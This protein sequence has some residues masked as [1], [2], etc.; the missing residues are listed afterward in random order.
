MR[1]FGRLM[2]ASTAV[3]LLLAGCGQ[4]AGSGAAANSS[5]PVGS[6]TSSAADS[7]RC[8][9]VTEDLVG[10][11]FG[12]PTVQADDQKTEDYL[13]GKDYSCTFSAGA[14]WR[15][16]V[17]LKVFPAA[18]SSARD[19]LDATL[20]RSN[21]YATVVDGV[22]DAAAYTIRESTI[23]QFV[24]I[25]KSGPDAHAALLIGPPGQD[26]ESRYSVIAKQVLDSAPAS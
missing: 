6:T 16:S 9:L 3:A 23:V 15:L 8:S 4:D 11:T 22:G 12:L 7:S 19:L 25:R 14:T 1:G 17:S 20:L 13:G 21:P 18:Q 2:V 5:T 10:S 26:D 24:A